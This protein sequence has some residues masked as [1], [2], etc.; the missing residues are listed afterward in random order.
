MPRLPLLGLLALLVCAPSAVASGQEL[1]WEICA[2]ATAPSGPVLRDCRSVAGPI[3]PQ[4]RE[5]WIRSAVRRP[6]P[7]QREALYIG[8]AA[9][10][11]VWLDGRRLG[12]NGRPG[13]TE[14]AEVPGRYLASFPLPEDEPPPGGQ[15]LVVHMSSFHGGLRLA[16][17]VAGLR[18]GAYPPA[19][20][21]PLL[22]VTFAAAG[23][24]FA[25]AFGFG[26]I[27][28]LR[29]T[30]SSLVL[31]AMAGVAGLQAIV[32]NLRHLVAYAYP[33]HAWRLGAIWLLA[34]TFAVLLASYAAGR[35]APR[36]RERLTLL[37]LVGVAASGLAPGFDWKTSLALLVGVLTA[38]GAAAAGV[39]SRD[40]AARIMLAY[41]AL[42]LGLAAALPEWLVDVSF[43]LL[44]GG[45]LLPLL[46][47]EVVRLARE[48]R[49]RE[50]ALVSA[51]SLPN[52]LTVASA[53]GVELV[54]ISSILAV[55]GADDYVELRLVGSRSLLHAERLERL[56]AQLPSNF[57]RIHRSAIAN[58]AHAR[59]LERVGRGWRLHFDDDS[60]L[61][62]S[63]SRLPALK[64]ALQGGAGYALRP[65]GE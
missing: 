17:P 7:A 51:A 33:L 59:R 34:A 53:R 20:R 18:I 44:A 29:R 28:A 48:D 41:L 43:F 15:V 23:A 30:R 65:A 64:D 11:E 55:V 12:A 50:A 62:V 52:R 60:A 10:S 27:H 36:G 14:A 37:A 4:G 32:E 3:D 46:A 58:L 5:I 40:P 61:P 24:L 38:S 45:L 8:A 56:A 39:R 19:S 54:S 21:A 2:G 16:A 9:S 1:A 63:R 13:A 47:V 57:L 35:F 26:V 42:F 31:A 6:R 49:G 22:A 25:A